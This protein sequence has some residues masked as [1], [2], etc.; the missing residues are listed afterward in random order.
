MRPVR[1]AFVILL[2]A[3]AVVALGL[4][5]A[6]DQ[7]TLRQR[8]DL[9]AEDPRFPAYLAALIGADLSRGNAFDVLTNGD[10][11][12]PPMLDAIEKA[13]HR[14]SFETYI[15]DTGS[16]ADQFT[17]ALERAARRGVTVQLTIDAVGGSSIEKDHIGR[18]RS[19]GCTIVQFN[20]PRWYSIEEVN[21]RTHR[22]ILVVDGAVAFTGGAGVADHWLGHAQD[23]DHWRDT[24]VRIAGPLARLLEAGFYENFIEGEQPVAPDLDAS[25]AART[26][27][28][29]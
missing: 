11:L 8:S 4:V 10:Q 29:T 7:T 21:Y 26:A 27:L 28:I 16:V 15:Y 25:T 14:I 2:I 19:A 5:F 9:A 12:F 22:K 20:A 17:A 6:Q 1:R 3:A 24:Q 18:L 23:K 13:K